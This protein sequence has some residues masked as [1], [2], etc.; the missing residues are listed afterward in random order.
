MLSPERER[1]GS[2][3]VIY[4]SSQIFI[5]YRRLGKNQDLDLYGPG[6]LF[7]D[8]RPKKKTKKKKGGGPCADHPGKHV[9]RWQ[10][11]LYP[12]IGPPS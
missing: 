5:I 7:S 3:R 4:V 1:E 10:P 9:P 2:P 12:G 6:K 11:R 8:L